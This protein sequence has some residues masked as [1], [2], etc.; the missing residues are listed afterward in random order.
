MKPQQIPRKHVPEANQQFGNLRVVQRVTD[1][2]TTKSANLIVRVRV[3]C[4]CGNRLTIP[5]YY[6]IRTSPAP[7]SICGSCRRSIKTTYWQEYRIW[8]MMHV[9][10][11]N[12]THRF[13]KHYG[14]RG[15]KVCAEWQK[16]REDGMGFKN[17]LEYVGE[18]PTPKHS[19]DRINNNLGYQPF[20]ADGITRQVKWSTG[21]EQ[22]AN[23]RSSEQVQ[24]DLRN[25]NL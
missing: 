15:I 23:Q 22:R 10:C 18:R 11:E 2:Q 14:G 20:Q 19:I 13:F 21:K 4:S 6:L 16:S 1:D 3:E 25:Q 12:P 5:Y 17:F 24:Q 9:R 7:K 8:N